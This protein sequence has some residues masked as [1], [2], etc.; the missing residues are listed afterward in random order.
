MVGSLGIDNDFERLEIEPDE[1]DSVH[2]RLGALGNDERHRLAHKTDSP[3]GKGGPS[4][5][6][7]HH[8]EA[9]AGGKAEVGGGEHGHDARCNGGGRDIHRANRGVSQS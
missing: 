9:D 2:G 1:L 3:I 5:D 7:R 4:E 6:L 8:L